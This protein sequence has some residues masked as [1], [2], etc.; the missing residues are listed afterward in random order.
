MPIESLDEAATQYAINTPVERICPACA[1]ST[2]WPIDRHAFIAGAD[3]M[4]QQFTLHGTTDCPECWAGRAT[5]Y[6]TLEGRCIECAN[7]HVR[8]EAAK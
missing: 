1:E 2:G 8:E 3:W 7:K 5:L 4:R 6:A